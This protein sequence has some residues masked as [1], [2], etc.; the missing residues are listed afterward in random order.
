MFS[1]DE[2][3]REQQFP[4]G[5]DRNLSPEQQFDRQWAFA[6]LDEARA[7][8]H[9]ECIA[10]GKSGLYDRIDLLDDRTEKPLSYAE[11]AGQL[12]MS[13]SA[14]KSA[15][16]RLRGRYGELVREVVARTVDDPAEVDGEIRHLL[17][18]IG[19]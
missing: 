13:I 18:V 2:G 4:E 10:S 5:V 16:L 15:V 6:V 17:S 11:V 14:V 8:L 9:R 1:L 3:S 12:G 7:T 19:N